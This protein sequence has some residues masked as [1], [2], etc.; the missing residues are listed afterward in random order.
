M[1]TEIADL[2]ATELVA[3]YADKSLSPVEAARAALER[4]SRHNRAVNAYCLVDEASAMDAAA[5]SE[6]RWMRGEPIGLVDGVPCSIKDIILTKGWPTLRGSLT[7]SADQPWTEN[8]PCVDRLLDHG[9]VL[10]GKTCVPEF[11][12]KGVTDNPLTG[13]TRNPWDVSK[14]PGGSSGGASVAAALGMGAL[15]IGTDGGGSIRIPASFTGIVGIKPTF[16]RVPAYPLS[17]F[18]DVAHLGPMT[19]SV[20]DAALMLQVIAQPDPRDWTAM[21][22]APPDYSG[23]LSKGIAGLRIG[24]SPDLGFATVD[25]EVAAIVARAVGIFD[26]IG[27]SVIPAEV[28]L[29]N[30]VHAVFES[31]WYGVAAGIGARMTPDDHEKLD[32]QLRKAMAFGAQQSVTQFVSAAVTRAMICHALSMMFQRFDLLVTPAT[33]IV[34]FSAGQEC[35]EPGDWDWTR[36]TPFSYPF[37]LSQ[38]PAISIPCGVTAAGLPVGLQIVGPRFSEVLVLRAAHALETHLP[39][40]RPP[41][42]S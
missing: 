24:Y 27:A 1:G 9:A 7:V 21:P 19:R 18:G 12:W 32:P 20:A 16:G 36:W 11:G 13:T 10:L 2:T 37:N 4:I 33:P 34:A 42:L 35:P 38:Q 31:H 8:A 22:F 41:L 3:M 5:A 40:K 28:E 15:H 26:A 17:P 25:P 23:C 14:T 6:A 29:S 39:M 30:E